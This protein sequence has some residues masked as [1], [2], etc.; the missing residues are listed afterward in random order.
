MKCAALDSYSYAQVNVTAKRLRVA[1]K[2][3]N[4]R[5]VTESDGRACG[6]YVL[7]AKRH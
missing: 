7:K 6:P 1:L 3:L 5:T 2:D 4:G